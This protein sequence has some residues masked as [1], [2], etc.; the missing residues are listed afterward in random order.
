MHF[1]A[2]PIDLP[3]NGIFASSRMISK[4][5]SK[6]GGASPIWT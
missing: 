5:M 2:N 3:E 6:D 4:P 1:A